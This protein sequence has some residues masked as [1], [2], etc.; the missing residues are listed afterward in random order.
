VPFD[1]D[2]GAAPWVASRFR[3]GVPHDDELEFFGDTE[4]AALYA[5]AVARL[6]AIGGVAI[7]IDFRPF[8]EC[9]ARCF[10]AVRGWRNDGRRWARSSKVAATDV[11]PT[12]GQ[13]ISGGS[14][15]IGSRR[16]SRDVSAEELRREAL[17]QWDAMDVLLLPTDRHDLHTGRGAR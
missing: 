14:K 2:A 12:V 5:R 4:A 10:T 3:F 17:T 15:Y 7:P 6:E 8:R 16:V 11:H 1:P 13:I 9:A